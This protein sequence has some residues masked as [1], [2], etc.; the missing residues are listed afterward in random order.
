MNYPG[1]LSFLE[2]AAERDSQGLARESRGG[3]GVTADVLHRVYNLHRTRPIPI[4][5]L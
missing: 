3:G 5:K 4:P 2:W 1:L